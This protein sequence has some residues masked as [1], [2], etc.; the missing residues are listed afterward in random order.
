MVV[1]AIEF[2]ILLLLRNLFLETM[3]DEQPVLELARPLLFYMVANVWFEAFRAVTRGIIRAI[4]MQ[5]ETIMPSIISQWFGNPILIWF[6]AF[7]LDLKLHG[8]WI[9]KLLSE[10][11]V[12]A[13]YLLIVQRA[14]FEMVMYKSKERMAKDA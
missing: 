2:F 4:D 5:E 3:T 12:D 1:L 7:F 13:A 11:Y 9:A 14:D 10:V 6:F 8:I